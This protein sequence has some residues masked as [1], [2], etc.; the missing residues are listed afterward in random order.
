MSYNEK[1]VEKLIRE[2]QEAGKLSNLAGEGT[3]E[4]VEP[5]NPYIPEDW[6]LAHKVM[7]NAEV[8]PPWIELEREIDGETM[9]LK[10]ARRDHIKWLRY[11]LDRAAYNYGAAYLSEIR[12]IRTSH[13]NW[14]SMHGR[15]MD[16]INQKITR[17][18]YI[19]PVRALLKAPFIVQQELADFEHSCP[20]IPSV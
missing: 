9:R 3:P 16:E 6:R 17:F 8:V 19:C 2:A 5:E 1:R 4:K 11:H 14:M 20:A 13:T 7:K 15:R 18:N 12:K 10:E